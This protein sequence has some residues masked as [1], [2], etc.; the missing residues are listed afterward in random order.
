M[1]KAVI[2]SGARTPVGNFGGSLSG[3]SAVELGRIASVE[4][5]LRAGISA[6][7][8]DEIIVG[9]ILSAG[10]GQNIARQIGI[11]AGTLETTPALTINQLCGSGL[12]AVMMAAQ[13]IQLGEA[14]IVLAGG[15]ES[16]SNAPY[17]LP[18]AR[19][20]YRMGDGSL[21]DSMILDGLTDAFNNYHMGVTAENI[22]AQW[23]LSR[24]EQDAFALASQN[25]TEKAQKEGRFNDEIV[26][27]L[28]PQRKG[29]PIIVDQDE[30]PKHGMTLDKLSKLRPAFKPDGTVTAGNA[31]GINDGAAMLVIMS[32]DKAHELGLT[33]LAT[34]EGAAYA[35]LDPKIMGYGPVPAT[36]KVL[37]KTGW[38]ISDLQLIEANEAFAA[39]SLAVVKDLGL[40]PT[41]VNVNGGAI[42]LGH[43]I[44]ASGARIL[45]SLIYEMKKRNLNK[46]LATLCIGGGQGIAMLIS[47]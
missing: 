11:Y 19:Y 7:I 36:R 25:K 6:E 44:G 3:L 43:P 2:I 26:N 18:K 15:T 22:A 13:L 24:E 41:I 9:N 4:A 29:E 1:K 39:Q 27:V 45:I 35:A 5:L 37:K 23:Q 21:V 47:R 31:S 34:I 30:F 32:E 20:G 42:A 14:E 8:V 10:L 16:M 40:D 38:N 12:R 33:P 17:L 28:I 46:G